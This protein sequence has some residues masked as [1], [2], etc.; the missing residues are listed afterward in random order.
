MTFRNNKSLKIID[1]Q[2]NRVY[3]GYTP[4][5]FSSMITKID[6]GDFWAPFH[7]TLHFCCF[8][9]ALKNALKKALTNDSNFWALE[10]TRETLAKA[11]VPS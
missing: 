9:V 6:F 10:L 11:N 1:V 3:A 7:N 8:K 2:Q 4:G 5:M